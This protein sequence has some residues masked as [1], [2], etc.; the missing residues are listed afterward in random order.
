MVMLRQLAAESNECIGIATEDNVGFDEKLKIRSYYAA[1]A[2][3]CHTAPYC[4]EIM[5][6]VL[7]EK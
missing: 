6:L 3:C 1:I 4:T 2:L 5:M 7:P